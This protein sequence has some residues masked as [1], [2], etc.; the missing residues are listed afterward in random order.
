MENSILQADRIGYVWNP[1]N[2]S[3]CFLDFQWYTEVSKLKCSAMVVEIYT[4]L[5]KK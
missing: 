3:P 4:S 2:L 5:I 1:V